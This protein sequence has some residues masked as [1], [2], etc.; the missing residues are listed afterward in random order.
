MDL[1]GLLQRFLLKNAVL[2]CATLDGQ[3]VKSVL[4]FP[5]LIF[6]K[7][8][9]GGGVVF[10]GVQEVRQ[11]PAIGS[12]LRG[13]EQTTQAGGHI[14]PRVLRI[15]GL[16]FSGIRPRVVT[17]EAILIDC[18][19][20]QA[21]LLSRQSHLLMLN[22]I[23]VWIRFVILVFGA[24]KQISLEVN[25]LFANEV[26]AKDRTCLRQITRTFFLSQLTRC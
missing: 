12:I 4:R 22:A 26:L 16:P 19:S 6:A 14:E 20:S 17:P 25:P 8:V 23:W 1:L 13:S 9:Q 5:S 3:N 15:S 7:K 11:S 24:R 18:D 2:H 10:E 21:S